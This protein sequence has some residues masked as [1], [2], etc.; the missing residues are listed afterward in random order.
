MGS[1]SPHICN[2]S[3]L[4]EINL[5]INSF[6]GP[7]P[8][9]IGLLRRLE[10]IEF[11]IDYNLSGPIPSEIRYLEK[12]RDLG[13]AK[14]KISGVIP[15]FIGNVTSLRTLYLRSC[16]LEGEI[17]ESIS[18]L[19]RLSNLNL[20]DNNLTC[21]IPSG[22][23]NIS[24]I[25]QFVVDFNGLHGPIPSTIGLTLPNLS[26]LSLGRN[27]FSG[28]VLISI[29]NASSLESLVLSFND[30][31]GPMLMFGGLLLFSSLYAEK[32]LVQDD[33]SF[34]SSLTNCTN[35]RAFDLSSPFISGQIPES[36]GNLSVNLAAIRIS[37]TQLRRKI[38]SGDIPFLFGNLSSIIKLNLYEN[39]FSGAIPK[40]LGVFGD[41]VT[42]IALKVLN[43]VV[44]GASK[45]FLAECNSL[46]GIRHRNL[47][48]ILS[49]CERIDFQ[50]NNFKALVYEFKANRSLD[51]W[52]YYNSEQE[53]GS[54][55]QLRNLDLIE[56]L[57]ITIDVAH[58]LEY[59]HSGI[60]S[61]I[62]HGDLKPSNII[63]DEDMNACV[64]DFGLSK[65]ISSVLP[66]RENSSTTGIKGTIGYVPPE[67]GTSNAISTEGDV[68]S[69]GILVLEMF[70]NKRPTDDSF[71]DQVNLHNFVDAALPD[72]VMEILDPLVRIGPRQ[73]NN[74]FEDC[75]ACIL[76][77][78]VWCSKE[79]PRDRIT[80][81]DV[82]SEL[83]KIQKEL[84]S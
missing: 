30:F 66:P 19:T 57:D 7:I 49:V 15:R 64:G 23:F 67:Y 44:K 25:E 47:V 16:G 34:V 9:E 51:K 53:E 81:S 70:T 48:K 39:N 33:F 20:G 63:L 74:K 22:L 73:N 68:Y 42:V 65:I 59:L 72:H 69:Y 13:L 79:M 43:L 6:S 28:R 83:R 14:N 29:S 56:R 52:L 50:G 4:R 60:G 38:P 12:L 61:V 18:Q 84:S 36:I 21:S 32:T 11:L 37:D 8:Q 2:L 71:M 77:I 24:T 41:G 17:P 45:S 3:F 75:M 76:N 40:S 54:D 5:Q 27:R 82:V 58:A 31:T 62:V 10:Y 46:R 80:M 55:A 35:L 26:F 78:G 1:L